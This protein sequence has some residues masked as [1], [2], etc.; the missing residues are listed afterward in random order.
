MKHDE[1]LSKMTLEEKASLMSGLNMWE[2]KPVKSEN[3]NIPSIWVS[4][5]PSGMR[6]QMGEGDQLGF[7]ESVIATCFPAATCIANTFNDELAEEVGQAL[8]EEAYDLDVA[9][10]L[11][12]GMNI[13]R[14]PLCGRCFEYFAEDPILA[15]HMAKAYVV[16]MKNAGV[17]SCIKHFACN[18]QELRRMENDSIVDERTLR[19]IYLT[20]FEYAIREGQ[21]YAIMSS[22]NSLNGEFANENHHLLVDILRDDWGFD[23]CVISD[24]GGNVDR[25]KAI[26]AYSSLEMPSTV[27][28]TDREIVAAVQAGELDEKDLDQSVD[29]LLTLIDRT[30]RIPDPER[31]RHIDYEKHDAVTKKAAEE[32]IVLLKNNDH[33][34]PLADGTNVAV[35]GEF[36]V[37]SRYE[38]AGSSHVNAHAVINSLDSLKQHTGLHIIGYEQGYKRF[39]KTKNGLIKK[40][41]KLAG[42]ADV[43][44]AYIGLHEHGEVEGIDREVYT[45]PENQIEMLRRLHNTG[46]KIV[47]VL[48]CGC[49]VDLREVEKYSDAILYTSLPGQSGQ[50]AHAEIIS[51]KVNPSGKL[52]ESFAGAFEDIPSTP[53][54][55]GREKTSEYRE[56]IYVG[57]RYYTTSGVKPLFCFGHGLS[58]SS[59]SYSDISVDDNGVSFK[60]R[61]DSEIKGKEA[62]QLYISL[63]ESRIFRARRELKGYVK[64]EL[65]PHEEKEV[66]IDFDDYSFRYWNVKTNHF[67]IEEG[68]YLIEIGASSEDIRLEGHVHRA[69]TTDIDPYEGLDIDC[70][71]N[72]DLKNIPDDQFA[73]ILGREIPEARYTRKKN[74]KKIRI[75]V[76]PN[77]TMRDLKY[78]KGWLGRFVGGAIRFLMWIL[79]VFKQRKTLDLITQG[80]YNQTVKTISRMTNGMFS[81]GQL[82]GLITMMNGHF[83]KGWG[84]FRRASKVKKALKKEAKAKAEA[85]EEAAKKAES[86]AAAQ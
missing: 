14:N 59:F 6:K 77:T 75:E 79:R 71:R 52:S 84:E 31:A 46:K 76:N 69:G 32:G 49:A 48:Q 41:C 50:I 36:A 4:D 54:Y 24:W 39:G 86:E 5:G 55:P 44:I 47:T 11:G 25:V 45:I 53:Y 15:G 10:V 16:G 42:Q 17:G 21:P 35:C 9:V 85:E 29:Y 58:Y 19:E 57:Y 3:V 61:N 63:P 7:N 64:V 1:I 13:K 34:L 66:R 22:Y 82:L 70:Y 12:P 20:G 65:E 78:A 51:G 2:T 23:G 18:N 56:G 30:Y 28:E 37:V 27:G 72:C 67:E 74:G 26:K 40:A 83:F 81:W 33:L 43:V 8:G 60:I 38:G 68:D 62:A 80:V 73:T